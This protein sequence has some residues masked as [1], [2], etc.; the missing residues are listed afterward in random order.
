MNSILVPK[1]ISNQ[2]KCCHPYTL[3]LSL[4]F[5]EFDWKILYHSKAN[6]LNFFMVQKFFLCF[7]DILSYEFLNK[8]RI[9]FYH[10]KKHH[11]S[12][13]YQK[14]IFFAKSPSCIDYYV[15]SFW[16]E[17]CA[18]MTIQYNG[19]NMSVIFR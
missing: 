14:F 11:F 19:L 4:S 9:F 13:S 15:K 18:M 5:L 16:K 8:N 10:I 2:K 1:C 17:M 7:E 12:S 6:I 3:F